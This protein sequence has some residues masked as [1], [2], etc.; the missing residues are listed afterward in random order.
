MNK[1]SLMNLVN[2]ASK[3]HLKINRIRQ[4]DPY[5]K[6]PKFLDR[7][8]REAIETD[9][10]RF[11]EALIKT[12]KGNPEEANRRFSQVALCAKDPAHRRWALINLS[13]MECRN[14]REAVMQGL[15]DTH[16]SV[17]IAAAFN[18]GLYDDSDMVNAFEIFFERNRFSLV[19]DGLRQASKPLL[20]LI[21]KAK[22]IYNEYYRL[23]D[24]REAVDK[25]S[26]S[27]YPKRQQPAL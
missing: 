11:R 1:R 21:D 14:A 3:D 7:L 27:E 17:R 10:H 16:R 18:T 2:T 26:F 19:A 22:K 12:L 24:N 25:N 15:R 20:P 8:C 23:E 5:I 4:S 13:L 6:D 9:N